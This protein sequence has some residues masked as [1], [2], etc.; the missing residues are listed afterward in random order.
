MKDRP[1]LWPTLKK[2]GLTKPSNDSALKYFSAEELNHHFAKRS[3]QQNPCSKQDLQNILKIP[4]PSNIKVPFSF[5]NLNEEVI[6]KS[7]KSC[8]SSSKGRSPDG[9]QLSTFKDIFFSLVPILTH[10]YNL[11]LTS[12]SFPSA[13]KKVFLIPLN[14]KQKPISPS[15]TRPIANLS[16]IS[17]P[18]EKILS[19]QICNYLES[20]NLIDPYQSGFRQYYSTQ[21]SLIRILDDAR[22]SFDDKSVVILISFDLTKAFDSLN[23]TTLLLRLRELGFSNSA[24]SWI[25][26]YLNNRKQSVI[27]MDGKLT[28]YIETTSGVPQGSNLGPLLFLIYINSISSYIMFS[29]H[30]LFADDL[31]IYFTTKLNNICNALEMITADAHS[32]IEW[33]LGNGLKPNYQKTAAM[34]LGSS[35][36][37][38]LLNS[39]GINSIQINGVNIQFTNNIKML[40]IYISS[41]LS[42]N[43]YLNNLTR[44]VNGVLYR[45]RYK[46]NILSL[47]TKKILVQSLIIPII[48]YCCVLLTDITD[49][50]NAKIDRLLNKTIRFIFCLRRDSHITPYRRQL[51]WLTALSRRKY[52]LAM[53]FYR[54]HSLQKPTY[55]NEFIQ[56]IDKN[57]RRDVRLNPNRD[58]IYTLPRPAKDFLKESFFHTAY[59]LWQTLPIEL[60]LAP[61]VETFRVHLF[62]Y[63]FKLDPH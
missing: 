3:S 48:D 30:S 7:L 43:I 2:I 58:L 42:W 17:K 11:S 56:K 16:H 32:I 13:W 9:L 12:N 1:K 53:Y 14:K 63:L 26:S 38:R 61:S 8:F 25:H 6:L 27:N 45:L 33:C 24:I 18:F 23:H 44:K 62:D 60:K 46:G 34:I 59:G 39:L 29:K 36:N 52:F 37:L 20:N 5:S 49:E 51:R 55:F 21:S 40:G 4:I 57:I 41:D 28:Q 47:E 54:Y 50:L 31:Q 35:Y 15:D 19:L 22:K 10:I